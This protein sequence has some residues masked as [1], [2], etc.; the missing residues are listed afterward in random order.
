MRLRK[1]KIKKQ[2][3]IIINCVNVGAS[4]ERIEV[5]V[6]DPSWVWCLCFKFDSEI[7][8]ACYKSGLENFRG[9]Q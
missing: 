6:I 1:K 2:V 4:L 8:L 9:P 7:L 5:L 3:S